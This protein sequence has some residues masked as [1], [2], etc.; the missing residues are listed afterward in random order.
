MAFS[1]AAALTDRADLVA[2]VIE[3]ESIVSTQEAELR[4]LRPPTAGGLD[5]C[6]GSCGARALQPIARLQD[7]A[8]RPRAKLHDRLAHL[9]RSDELAVK[10]AP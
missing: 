8:R 6:Q 7:D 10:I 2:R 5:R 9:D 1:S 4:A 3:L